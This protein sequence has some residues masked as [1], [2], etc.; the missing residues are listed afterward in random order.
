V[1]GSKLIAGGLITALILLIGTAG[2]LSF[3][4]IPVPADLW[5][6]V[7]IIASAL[8]GAMSIKAPKETP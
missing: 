5:H 7:T 1:D 2:V 3:R 6:S 4:H 8:C